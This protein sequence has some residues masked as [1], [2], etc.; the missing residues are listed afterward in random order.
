MNG[1]TSTTLLD[2][3]ALSVRDIRCDGACRHRSPT[4]CATS[5]AIVLPY[6]GTFARHLG[7]NDAIAEA[8]QVLFFNAGEEY[9]ISHPVSGG[10][11]CLSI[12][13]DDELMLEI[14]PA[15]RI[16]SGPGIAFR[17]Q[18]ARIDP[19]VQTI[20]ALL[21]HGLRS[22]SMEPLQGET[23]ALSLIRSAVVEGRLPD[24]QRSVGKHKLVDRAKL[25]LMADPG[26]RW[27]LAAIGKE[28]GCSPV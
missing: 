24:R 11:A 9:S 6:H 5:T 20:S 25:A 22:R 3:P 26:R 28:V 17:E 16:K 7:R 12:A 19:S 8:N 4:E 2:S 15:S 27:T 1:V 21:R 23:L 13:L 10:D 18:R 14:A